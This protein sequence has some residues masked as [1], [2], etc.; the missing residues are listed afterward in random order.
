[1][2]CGPEALARF[3]GVVRLAGE[4]S[5]FNAHPGELGPTPWRDFVAFCEFSAQRCGAAGV[6]SSLRGD[7]IIAV[8]I[9]HLGVWISRDRVDLD[10]E[11]D[12][13][14]FLRDADLA[15]ASRG[16]PRS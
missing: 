15:G 8:F 12:C 9:P 11:G 4:V 1:M 7:R 6:L 5:E 16:R 13:A 10:D 14:G 2:A 3:V